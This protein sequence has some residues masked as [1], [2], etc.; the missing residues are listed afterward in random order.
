LLILLGFSCDGV[1]PAL[2]FPSSQPAVE[3]THIKQ[4]GCCKLDSSQPRT[5]A[6]SPNL[7]LSP[8]DAAATLGLAAA[9]RAV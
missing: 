5:E 4:H 3:E 7:A 6:Y 2:L 9:Y 8:G 1:F